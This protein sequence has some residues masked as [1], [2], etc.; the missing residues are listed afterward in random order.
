MRLTFVA[1]DVGSVACASAS[2]CVALSADGD[3]WTTTDPTGGASAW[4]ASRLPSKQ[5]R[6][7]AS[8]LACPSTTLCIASASNEALLQST[9]P[10]GVGGTTTFSSGVVT[11]TDPA[12]PSPQWTYTSLA[13][14]SS[15]TPAPVTCQSASLCIVDNIDGTIFTSTDPA[16]GVW[17]AKSHN[18]LL[19]H[20]SCPSASLCVGTDGSGMVTSTDPAGGVFPHGPTYAAGI[21]AVTCASASLCVAV[22]TAGHVLTNTDP[23]AN[24]AYTL[25]ALP[26]VASL[27]SIT[28]PSVSSCVAFDFSGGTIATS[29]DPAGGATAWKVGHI[30]GFG[31]FASAFCA[32]VSLCLAADY[33][34]N[35]AVSTNPTGSA[36]AWAISPVAS[37][38]PLSDLA[39]PSAALCIARD[40]GGNVLTTNAP[41]AGVSSWT[42]T[43]VDPAHAVRSVSCVSASLCAVFDSGGNVLTSTNPTGGAATWN[44]TRVDT[45]DGFAYGSCASGPVCAGYDYSNN[46]VRSTNPA[47][48]TSTWIPGGRISHLVCPS[49]SLCLA[50]VNDGG[51]EASTNRFASGVSVYAPDELQFDIRNLS[52]PSTSL[53][54][55]VLTG[56]DNPLQGVGVAFSTDPG[57][58]NGTWTKVLLPD[59]RGLSD[60]IAGITSVSCPTVSFCVATGNNGY[61]WTTSDP[62]GGGSAWTRTEVDPYVELETVACPSASLCV[63]TDKFGNVVVGTAASSPPPPPSSAPV[64]TTD[65]TSGVTASAATLQG[66]VNPDGGNVTSCQFLWGASDGPYTHSAPCQSLPGGGSA[67][68]SVSATLS[69]LVP[70]GS[71]EF[72]LRARNAVGTSTGS[73][74]RFQTPSTGGHFVFGNP[75]VGGASSSFQANL[76]RVNP[77]VL[78]AAGV[79]R[80]LSIYLQ[81]TGIAGSQTVELMLYRDHGGRPG[82]LLGQSRRLAFTS[83]DHAGWYTPRLRHRVSMPTGMYWIGVLTGGTAGVAGWRYD[84]V[85][86]RETRRTS[87]A[88]GPTDPFGATDFDAAVMSLYANLVP[89][90]HQTAANARRARTAML[91]GHIRLHIARPRC[92]RMCG[93]GKPH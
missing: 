68:V 41:G 6:V 47:G 27:Q 50:N 49:A 57:N 19:G 5:L 11:T 55:G 33:D 4:M 89:P 37:F 71:Y 70:G 74:Q 38:N 93:H 30:T 81:P 58:P 35:L 43:A 14:Q 12:D 88:G 52:C 44:P 45:A 39:C 75:S 2:L 85:G 24:Q 90:P 7:D 87:F 42:A 62:T 23:A 84:D 60:P 53:C 1:N 36:S 61:I 56:H 29:T 8:T 59:N 79:A 40:D 73:E 22:D 80:S 72:R 9:G 21:N 86:T 31:M 76:E 92:G 66:T 16:A 54:V 63:A 28:C 82:A 32:S 3:V 46:S 48:G 51:L 15:L 78:Y 25:T 10:A 65:G 91:R 18:G 69:G 83:T 77:Y 17:S 34:G 64:V 20:L 67:P 26:G 13:Y